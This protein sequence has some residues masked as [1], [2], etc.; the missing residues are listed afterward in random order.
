MDNDHNQ[1]HMELLPFEIGYR[2]GDMMALGERVTWDVVE[3][4]Q[5]FEYWLA[6]CI[7]DGIEADIDDD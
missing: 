2:I 6:H 4:H 7:D 5:A 1:M 3:D